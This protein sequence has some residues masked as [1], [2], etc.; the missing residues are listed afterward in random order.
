MNS[1]LIITLFSALLLS[2]ELAAKEKGKGKNINRCQLS[3]LN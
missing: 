2:G 3:G 1:L